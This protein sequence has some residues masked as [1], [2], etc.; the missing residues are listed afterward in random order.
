MLSAILCNAPSSSEPHIFLVDWENGAQEFC[1]TN[2]RAPPPHVQIVVFV[3]KASEAAARRK[4]PVWPSVQLIVALTNAPEAADSCLQQ[5]VYMLLSTEGR[6]AST[7]AYFIVCG[8]EKGYGELIAQCKA[9]KLNIELTLPLPSLLQRLRHVSACVQCDTF[10]PSEWEFKRH[11]TNVTCFHCQASFV[12]DG[13]RAATQERHEPVRLPQCPSLCFVRICPGNARSVEAHLQ[14][15]PQCSE[16]NKRFLNVEF[17][18]EHRRARKAV[19]CEHCKCVS[20]ATHLEYAMHAKE[21]HADKYPGTK[22]CQAC[23]IPYV[24]AKLRK[25]HKAMCRP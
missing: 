23:G 5:H 2:S 12:C 8:G 13:E 6:R 10:L 25:A 9:R 22:C 20:F 15:H 14:G 21:Q 16:C 18:A 24:S 3:S 7:G 17:L 11:S 4:L 1:S 19:L